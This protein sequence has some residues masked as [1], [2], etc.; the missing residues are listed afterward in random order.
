MAAGDILVKLEASVDFTITL[1]SL[2]N[3]NAR[4]SDI[5]G[6]GSDFPAALCV[7]KIRSSGSAPSNGSIAEF[8]LL[9]DD[10]EGTPYITDGGGASDAAITIENAAL[11]STMVFTN[12]TNKDFYVDF[13]TAPLGPLG[14]S[15]GV[16]V[17]NRTG[18]S[19]N[20]TGSNHYIRY[21]YYRPQIQS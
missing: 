7:S 3:G 17:K 10:D 5:E 13:D 12:N 18:Q 14:S 9:R 19:F 15:W 21:K 16:A 2:G 6:N 11:L 4:Q 8:Y 20:A 1:A